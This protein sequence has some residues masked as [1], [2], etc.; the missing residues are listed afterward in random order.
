MS[1]LL[2]IAPF[3]GSHILLSNFHFFIGHVKTTCLL[4]L[5]RPLDGDPNNAQNHIEP[6]RL[7]LPAPHSVLFIVPIRAL[8]RMH[9]TLSTLSAC[10]K[11]LDYRA[12]DGKLPWAAGTSRGLVLRSRLGNESTDDM[13][14][15]V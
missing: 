12:V 10:T 6:F 9:T 15:D 1:Y 13:V 2:S 14:D 7:I 11:V 8:R 4:L 5:R 3:Q